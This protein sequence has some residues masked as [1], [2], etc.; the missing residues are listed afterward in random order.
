MRG[1]DGEVQDGVHLGVGDQLVDGEH[2]HP[3]APLGGGLRAGAVEV[4]DGDELHVGQTVEALQVLA[5]DDPAADHAD[6]HRV[7]SFA[8]VLPWSP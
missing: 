4:R 6:L 5:R 2:P 1:G 8:R 7:A 3:F